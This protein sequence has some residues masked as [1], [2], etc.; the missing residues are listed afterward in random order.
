MGR[1]HISLLALTVNAAGALN[2]HRFVGHDGNTAVAAGNALGVAR[3]AAAI[4]E[5]LAVDVIGTAIV[6]AGGAISAGAEIEV[7]AD[8]VAVTKNAG[9]T[10][11][12]IAPGESASAAGELIEVLLIA[13]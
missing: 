13:N 9:V 3:T 8:G 7:G 6:E 1:Q 10:V 11:A 12:R 4:G 2:P 5:D